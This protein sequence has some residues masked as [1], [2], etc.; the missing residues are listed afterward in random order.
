M[1]QKL[2]TLLVVGAC[3]FG[4]KAQDADNMS[5]RVE[6]RYD[7]VGL[8]EAFQ[9]SYVLENTNS[10]KVQN[11]DFI[12]FMIVSG[13]MQSSKMSIING[14][15]SSSVTYTYILQA[16]SLGR[17]EL[18]VLQV[19]TGNGTIL[20]SPAREIIIIEEPPQ[21]PE[22]SPFGHQMPF[23]FDDNAMNDI[24]RQQEEMLRR[25]QEMF[26]NPNLFSDPF[27]MFKEM[28]PGSSDNIFDLFKNFD[29]KQ[30]TPPQKEEKTYKL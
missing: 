18:P 13:P 28:N 19:E 7:T 8:Y 2:L 15:R 27:R 25:H 9:V 26:N 23:G 29:F 1:K 3:S 12:D 16:K 30:P 6:L 17:Y 24:F 11:P 21:R 22:F 14:Q 20:I 5:L 4:L 10:A